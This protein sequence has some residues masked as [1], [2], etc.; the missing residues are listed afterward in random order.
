MTSSPSLPFQPWPEPT[1]FGAIP[2]L[3][4]VPLPQAEED[5]ASWLQAVAETYG[6]RPTAYLAHLGMPRVSDR[7]TI[8]D[9]LILNPAPRLLTRLQED[10]GIHG[11]RLAAMTLGGLDP[12]LAAAALNHRRPCGACTTA[13][14][15]R[16]GR[17]VNL[18]GAR[19][20]WRV[21]CPAH[22][23]LPKPEEIAAGLDLAPVYARIREILT[24]LD[25]AVFDRSELDAHMPFVYPAA[26]VGSVVH[27]TYLLNSFVQVRLATYDPL[28]DRA[29][30]Q[31]LRTHE[32]VERGRPVPLPVEVRND[33]AVS[34]LL[35]WQ[36]LSTP[37]W[38]LLVGL[39][40]QAEPASP[41]GCSGPAARAVFDLLL[42]AWPAEVIGD[43][44]IGFRQSEQ[45]RPSRPRRVTRTAVAL[46]APYGN[47]PDFDMLR[48]IA[49]EQHAAFVGHLFSRSVTGR[50]AVTFSVFHDDGPFRYRMP[51]AAGRTA[52]TV[53]LLRSNV[54]K[55]RDWT[56][57][58]R[59]L[60]PQA[61]AHTPRK[62]PEPPLALMSSETVKAVVKRA[63][64]AVGLPE[65]CLDAKAHRRHWQ[66]LLAAGRDELDRARQD[67]LPPKPA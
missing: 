24:I 43:L 60:R 45:V 57:H 5:I 12:D 9:E 33:L 25:R 19:A 6:M 50:P 51:P 37:R 4:V 31:V 21:V 3:P 2:H 42:D 40:L 26:T 22:P 34:L 48:A 65:A 44:I 64:L 11:S 66:K 36:L 10:T 58:L 55:Q 49:S 67:T 15:A 18:L 47:Q 28:R 61:P 29:T 54:W 30:F 41:V 38:A 53:A 46:T 52:A 17:P 35:A 56:R 59:K 32:P 27:F 14:T 13:A 8:A 16:A 20:V 1:V 39:R 7:S 63:V 23:P 62:V